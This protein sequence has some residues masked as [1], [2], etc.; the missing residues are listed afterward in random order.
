MNPGQLTNNNQEQNGSPINVVQPDM[1]GQ[2]NSR[3]LANGLANPHHPPRIELSQMGG[4]A[5]NASATPNDPREETDSLSEPIA[6]KPQNA[7]LMN[8]G[9]QST[10]EHEQ[11]STPPHEN[12]V[13]E[14]PIKGAGD[15]LRPESVSWVEQRIKGA[16][17]MEDFYREMTGAKERYYMSVRKTN[18]GKGA[19][20]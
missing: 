15:G 3:E 8:V 1:G 12:T 13:D 17:R 5:I 7:E 4:V 11:Q 10:Q 18:D 20:K 19:E 9:V 14:S 16:E 6:K 2:E